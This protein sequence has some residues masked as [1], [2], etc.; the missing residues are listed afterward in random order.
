MFADQIK[1]QKREEE[2]GGEVTKRRKYNGEEGTRGVTEKRRVQW[3]N[4]NKKSREDKAR[5]S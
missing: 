5:K 2:T 1:E 3:E 4:G